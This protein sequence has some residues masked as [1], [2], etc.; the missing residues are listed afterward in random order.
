MSKIDR[1]TDMLYSV[2]NSLV[3]LK[4]GLHR[5]QELGR[6]KKLENKYS[7]K[8][9][10]ILGNGPSVKQQDLSLLS[11][12][13]VFTVNQAARN[14]SFGKI[15]S[16]FHFWADANFFMIDENKPEDMELLETMKNVNKDNKDIQVFFPLEQKGF[17]EKFGI[18]KSLNVNYFLTRLYMTENYK[19]NIDFTKPIPSFGTVVQWC[20]IAAVYMG[21]SEIYLMGCDNTSLMVTMKSALKINDDQDYG[22]SVTENEKKRM[23]SIVQRNGLEAYTESYLET[24]KGYRKLYNYCSK[25][26]IKLVNCSAQTVI[27]SV[28]RE[29]YEDVIARRKK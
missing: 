28:P 26:G 16:N 3:M 4:S 21:F 24:L 27:D 25:R 1:I 17:V 5:E 6:N 19:R 18:D 11:D 23:E 15:K 10:F 14:E 7:G 20:V 29:N 13:Y 22:Y 8:R 2:K 12:E 9:C